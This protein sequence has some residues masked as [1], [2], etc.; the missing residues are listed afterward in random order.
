[1]IRTYRKVGVND[2]FMISACQKKRFWKF[3]VN[4]KL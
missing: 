2:W 1:M 4:L 3:R